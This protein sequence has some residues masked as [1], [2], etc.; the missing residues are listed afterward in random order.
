[1]NRSTFDIDSRFEKESSAYLFKSSLFHNEVLNL[2][3]A[4]SEKEFQIKGIDAVALVNG[5]LASVDIK[6]V[7]GVLPTFSQEMRNTKSGKIGWLLNNELLTD[8]YLFVYHKIKNGTG[9][10]SEDKKNLTKDNI[11]YT[12]AI[13][14]SKLEVQNIILSELGLKDINQLRT[15]IDRY[16]IPAYKKTGVTKITYNPETNKIKP[17]GREDVYFVVSDKIYEQPVNC[18]IKRRLLE[19]HATQVFEIEE[20]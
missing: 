7:A 1:M 15:L 19:S 20:K 11:K 5:K 12:K 16:V 14:I 4:V 13:L 10:Y 3:S 8:Y 2:I 6:A 18:I 9:V 17:Y